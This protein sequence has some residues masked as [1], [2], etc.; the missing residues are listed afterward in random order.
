MQ[1]LLVLLA[2]ERHGVLGPL[3]SLQPNRNPVKSAGGVDRRVAK[4]DRFPME[5]SVFSHCSCAVVVCEGRAFRHRRTASFGCLVGGSVVATATRGRRPARRG[6][7]RASQRFAPASRPRRS[8]SASAAP[9]H[10]SRSFVLGVAAAA[11]LRRS[12]RAAT[13]PVAC[14]LHVCM[15]A[16]PAG[17]LHLAS[18]DI[19]ISV[20]S[21]LDSLPYSRTVT[22]GRNQTHDPTSASRHLKKLT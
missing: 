18:R 1:A 13:S 14:R 5:I 2:E 8:A 22:V 3:G 6:G 7:R 19:A 20:T 15:P 4:G 21:T 12:A 17:G 10:R 11:C 9:D 16:L